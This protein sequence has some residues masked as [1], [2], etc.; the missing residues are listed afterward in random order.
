MN[1]N[2]CDSLY[3]KSANSVW[4]LSIGDDGEMTREQLEYSDFESPSSSSGDSGDSAANEASPSITVR[5]ASTAKREGI[6]GYRLSVEAVGSIGM[7]Y[8]IFVY[9]RG[10]PR[11]NGG[12]FTDEFVNV[13]SPSDIEETPEDAP[14]MESGMQYF[15]MPSVSLMLRN[16]DDLE[17]AKSEI[18]AD[19]DALV[20]SYKI[21]GSSGLNDTVE[22][23]HA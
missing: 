22:V 17:L 10:Q 2:L 15:R 20:L 5:Y 18:M 4:R 3:L 8:K 23:V 11:L 12:E 16:H 19:V 7:P 6:Y 21:I 13:A 9:R 14:V 1:R